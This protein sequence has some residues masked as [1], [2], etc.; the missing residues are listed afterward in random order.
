MDLWQLHIF[1]KVVELKSF[2][3]A[4]KAVHLSQPTISSHI[5][6]LEEHF[7]CRLIDRLARQAVP[8]KSGE[9]LYNYA[10][11]LISLR[12]EA[13]TA[14]AEFQ[15][16]IKGR[17]AI[18]GSTIPGTYI[19]PRLVGAFTRSHPEV[20][21]A[22][23]IGD[24]EKIIE[25]TLNGLIEFGIVGAKSKDKRIA[26][27]KLVED[28]MCLIVPAG[29]PWADRKTI[30]PSGLLTEPFISRERGSGTLKSIQASLGRKG[31]SMDAFNIVA[32][33]GS[34]EAVCQ[35]I[36]SGVGVS[37][38][39]AIAV[40]E[41]LQAGTLKALSIKGV[42][43]KRAFYITTHKFRSPS[44]L[45]SAFLGFIRSESKRRPAGSNP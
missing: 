11:R 6:D 19:L 9:L 42:D 5:R 40:A 3:K 1:C 29:H 37:I 24:T 2:S 21:I 45:C 39:S 25:E 26:Q 34:T 38:L 33:M 23:T 4:G 18:G 41:E 10:R 27:E 15:G 44:P 16:R 35:G 36:K 20:T 28:E 22:L 13:E 7:G 32:E 8:T 43:L 31:V 14:L 30:P 12:D 17:L